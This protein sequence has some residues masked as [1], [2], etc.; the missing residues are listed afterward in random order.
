MAS[1]AVTASLEQDADIIIVLTNNGGSAAAV[2]KYRP[3]A[4]ILVM[5]SDEHVANCCALSRGAQPI[6]L[7]SV[8][9]QYL[10]VKRAVDKAKELGIASTGSKAVVMCCSAVEE[11]FRESI[12]IISL[13]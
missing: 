3:K 11:G 5:T 1:A 10:T 8:S 2:A 6:L 13:E 9:S 4:P 7:E 12:E